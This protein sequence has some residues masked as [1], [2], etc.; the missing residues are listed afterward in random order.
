MTNTVRSLTQGVGG[1]RTS[2]PLVTV[3]S[4]S[5]DRA[6]LWADELLET[7]ISAQLSK[8]REYNECHGTLHLKWLKL[9]GLFYIYFT[10][11]I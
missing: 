4:C 1:S 6:S 3:D 5:G 11:K 10:I 7:V 8:P 9:S 2:S